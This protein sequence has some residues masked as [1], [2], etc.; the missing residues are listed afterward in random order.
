[1]TTLR[2]SLSGLSF[3]LISAHLLIA[4]EIPPPPG[5]VNDLAQLLHQDHLQILE[6]KLA[7]FERNTSHQVAVLTIP[8]LQG[9]NI[10]D[11]S[12]RVAESWRI[13]RK[14]FDNGVILIIALK[15]RKLRIEVGYGLEGVLPDAIANQIIREVIVPH[16][17]NNDYGAGVDAGVNAILKTVAGE[18]LRDPLVKS[19]ARKHSLFTTLL[20]TVS[21]TSLLAMAFGLTQKSLLWGAISGGVTGATVGLFAALEFGYWMWI[22]AILAG[23]IVSPLATHYAIQSWGRAWSAKARRSQDGWARD[24]YYGRSGMTA[25]GGGSDGGG[26]SSFG[27]SSGGSGGGF[28]GG[29]ASGGW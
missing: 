11:F 26:S 24:I 16:F 29:G 3:L 9:E 8:S 2:S 7:E 5:R 20:G 18:S 4:L 6:N 14:G 15:D 21:I 10:E 23:S 28:G 1:L 19:K 27:G 13:G 12:I 22:V 25:G 17:R